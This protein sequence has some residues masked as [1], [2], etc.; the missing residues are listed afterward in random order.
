MLCTLRGNV[1]SPTSP[2]SSKSDGIRELSVAEELPEVL[3]KGC[4]VMG[5]WE[6]AAFRMNSPFN[7]VSCPLSPY[8]GKPIPYIVRELRNR[9]RLCYIRQQLDTMRVDCPVLDIVSTLHNAQ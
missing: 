9:D 2:T 7:H 3:Q 8:Q 6:M 4:G 5:A 1:T